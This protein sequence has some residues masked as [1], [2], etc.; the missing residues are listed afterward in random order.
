[1]DKTTADKTTKAKAKTREPA[2][3]VSLACECAQAGACNCHRLH[4]TERCECSLCAE[5]TA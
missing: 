5:Q 2:P 4:I 1:M 3:A